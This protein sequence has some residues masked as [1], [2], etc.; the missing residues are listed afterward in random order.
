MSDLADMSFAE[1]DQL[2]AAVAREME[3]RAKQDA[4]DAAQQEDAIE[5]MQALELV[6]GMEWEQLPV[7]HGYPFGFEV[8]HNGQ[9][10]RST[11]PNNVWPPSSGEAWSEFDPDGKP[12]PWVQPGSTNPYLPGDRVLHPDHDEVMS[13]WLNHHPA[14][15]WSPMHL[16]HRDGQPGWE[17]LGHVDEN[18]N[19]AEPEPEPEPEP[20]DPDDPDEPEP[21]PEPEDEVGPEW[22]PGLNVVAGD[23]L[24][25]GGQR[26]RVIQGHTTLAGW[27]PPNVP[28]LWELI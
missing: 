7:P 20:V 21:E 16:P 22:E 4:R 3:A 28:A 11:V 12:L 5:S 19:I 26:W 13:L 18:G 27:E 17:W 14:N 9:H 8:I 24:T 25:Y 2:R 10:K 6:Q 1:L 15:V 23:I